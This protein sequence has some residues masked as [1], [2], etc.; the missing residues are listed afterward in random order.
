MKYIRYIFI[1]VICI[2]SFTVYADTCSY[3]EQTILNNDFSNV[4]ITYEVVNDEEIDILIYNLT[5]N[6]YVS[7]NEP[8]SK[9]EKSIYYYN[10]DNGKYVIKRDTSNIEEYQFKI[11]SNISSCYGN[12]L[13]TKNIIKPKYNEYS[14]LSICDNEKLKNHSYCQKYI[15]SNINKS[16]SEVIS[17]LEEFLS[18]RVGQMT[19]IPTKEENKVDIKTIVTYSSIS[20][21]VIVLVVILLLIKKKRGEL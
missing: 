18:V 17:S 1:F 12:I 16:E 14:T 19:T 3:K 11:R 13:T 2:I 10:T 8:L 15:T 6:I 4:K 21:I 20:L 9:E 7:Y 5:D